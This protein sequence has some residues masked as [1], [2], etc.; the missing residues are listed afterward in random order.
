VVASGQAYSGLTTNAANTTGN[1]LLATIA[2]AG[3]TTAFQG[4]LQTSR[5][6]TLYWS[7][8][9]AQGAAATVDIRAYCRPLY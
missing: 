1:A 3:N 2:T 6:A 5:V 8:T 4:Y 9:T 7:L